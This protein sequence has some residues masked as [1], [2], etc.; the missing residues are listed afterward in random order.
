M[1]LP[2]GNLYG[3][4]RALTCRIKIHGPQNI[5]RKHGKIYPGCKNSGSEISINI[6]TERNARGFIETRQDLSKRARIFSNALGVLPNARGFIQTRQDFL[7]RA[8]IYSNARGV[9][10]NAQGFIRTRSDFR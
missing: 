10:P 2:Y 9:L 8:R 1:N 3:E 7:K 6:G 5:F 4:F